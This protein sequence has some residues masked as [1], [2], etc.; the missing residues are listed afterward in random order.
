[1]AARNLRSAAEDFEACKGKYVLMPLK[2]RGREDQ[3]AAT[4]GHLP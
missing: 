4:Y 1:M 2:W 3:Q